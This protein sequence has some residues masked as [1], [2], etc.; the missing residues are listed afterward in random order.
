MFYENPACALS[1]ASM[2]KGTVGGN[3]IV[4][5]ISIAPLDKSFV[6]PYSLGQ[7]LVGSDLVVYATLIAYREAPD[8]V[9]KALADIIGRRAFENLFPARLKIFLGS[10]NKTIEA[11]GAPESVESVESVNGAK[12]TPF[13]PTVDSSAH[14]FATEPIIS[15]TINVCAV[16][17]ADPFG[18]KL[19][20]RALEREMDLLITRT[21]TLAIENAIPQA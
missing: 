4:N 7:V 10:E 12:K 17:S 15:S 11:L 18:Q 2:L 9:R 3:G 1:E 14:K 13:G 6:Q 8:D 5:Y 20:E 19:M 21:G 16:V